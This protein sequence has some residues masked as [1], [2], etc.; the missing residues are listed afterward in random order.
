[1]ATRPEALLREMVEIASTI[2][3]GRGCVDAQGPLATMICAA[4]ASDLV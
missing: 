3:Y 4:S 1:V 2:L